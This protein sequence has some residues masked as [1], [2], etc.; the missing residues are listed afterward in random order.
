MYLLNSPIT[1]RLLAVCYRR[2]NSAASVVGHLAQF[3]SLLF[4]SRRGK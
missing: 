1:T 2:L 3:K 4:K